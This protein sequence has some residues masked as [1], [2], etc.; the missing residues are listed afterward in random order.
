MLGGWQVN[1]ILVAQ[2]GTPV[3][4]IQNGNNQNY[5]GLRPNIIGDP[6]LS[7][8]QRTLNQY[9]NTAAFCAPHVDMVDPSLSCLPAT[10]V[11]GTTFYYGDA[12]RN[13]VRGRAS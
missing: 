3:N 10:P 1:G 11:T 6:T 2:S 7:K 8:G 5:P 4:I 9:F 13:L 12:G